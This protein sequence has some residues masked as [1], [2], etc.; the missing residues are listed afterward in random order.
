MS[1]LES[2]FL[3]YL[4]LAAIIVGLIWYFRRPVK[5]PPPI[6]APPVSPPELPDLELP[7]LKDRLRVFAHDMSNGHSGLLRFVDDMMAQGVLPSD[8]PEDWEIWDQYD[9]GAG[10]EDFGGIVVQALVSIHLNTDA[11]MPLVY[12][13]WKEDTEEAAAQFDELFERMTGKTGTILSK[14]NALPEN[15]RYAKTGPEV[16]AAFARQGFETSGFKLLEITPPMGWDAYLFAAVPRR[17]GRRWNM[18]ALRATHGM[19][20]RKDISVKDAYFAAALFMEE[21]RPAG[22]DY[23][24]N[25]TGEVSLTV[26]PYWEEN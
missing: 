26:T 2:L 4:P 6:Q 12:F 19:D 14:I 20:S 24:K 18:R 3:N 7:P 17:L 15:I 8:A 1:F 11:V 10:P 21:Q 9:D 22:V 5:R 25:R 23:F 16:T 13:D